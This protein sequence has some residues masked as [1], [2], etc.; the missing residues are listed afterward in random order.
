MSALWTADEAVKATGGTATTQWSAQGISIDSRDLKTGDLFIALKDVR[1]GHDFVAAALAN[2][3]S[4]AMVSRIPAGVP[5]DAPLLLVNNVLTGLTDLA[6]ASRARSKAKDGKQDKRPH[7][8][9]R[10]CV[11]KCEGEQGT[12]W[13]A[14]LSP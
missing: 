12:L 11:S 9:H 14:S 7:C 6:R 3:A 8:S 2:G 10:I 13:A 4:A 5:E 1:D